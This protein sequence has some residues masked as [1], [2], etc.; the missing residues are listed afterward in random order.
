MIIEETK[1]LEIKYCAL[2]FI[3]AKSLVKQKESVVVYRYNEISSRISSHLGKL[4]SQLLKRRPTV[5]IKHPTYTAVAYTRQKCLTRP[6][7]TECQPT[8]LTEI[9]LQKRSLYTCQI[10]S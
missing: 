6:E 1:N 2:V 8:P 5:R 3:I 9:L 7:V 4:F 10:S